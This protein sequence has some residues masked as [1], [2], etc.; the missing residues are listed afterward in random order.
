MYEQLVLKDVMLDAQSLG[1]ADDLRPAAE[2]FVVAINCDEPAESGATVYFGVELP[3]DE[4]AEVKGRVVACRRLDTGYAVTIKVLALDARFPGVLIETLKGEVGPSVEGD[5]Q[6][7]W[8]VGLKQNNGDYAT[9]VNCPAGL[10]NWEQLEKIAELTRK[11]GGL[12]K[13]THAQRVVL[14]LTPEQTRDVGAQLESVGLRVGVLHS[15]VRNIRGCCGALCRWAQGTDA[16][17]L[18]MEIDKALFGRPLKFDVKIAVSDCPRNCMESYCVDIG[19]VAEK[20]TYDIFVGGVAS[21]T[22]LKALRLVKGVPQEQIVRSIE[23][24]LDWYDDRA[25]PG[26]RLYK[27]L[28]ALGAPWVDAAARE[29]FDRAAG[30][31][32]GLDMGVDMAQTLSRNL[33]RVLGV[34]RMRAE[35]GLV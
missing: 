11:G 32:V 15:G 3:I 9:V 10:L 18:S 31:F 5:G 33:A 17:A 29:V 24:I 12:A 23:R 35:L 27:T 20:G 2:P 28:E 21:S 26:E 13:L 1:L 7:R 34:G 22:H 19:L 6:L 14:L 16:L 30:V 8:A 25:R 4:I